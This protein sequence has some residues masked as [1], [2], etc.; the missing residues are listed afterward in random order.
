ME[1][2]CNPKLMALKLIILGLIL[3]LVRLYTTWDIWIV[4]GIIVII[5][6]LIMLIMPM[7]APVKKGR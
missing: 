5:K 4:I 1:N 7:P 2:C 3:V 6:A